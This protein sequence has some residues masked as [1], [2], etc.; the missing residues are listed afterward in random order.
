MVQVLLVLRDGEGE[1]CGR[2]LEFAGSGGASFA[3]LDQVADEIEELLLAGQLVHLPGGHDRGGV[4]LHLFN[5]SH[6]QCG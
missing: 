1:Q 4:G 3:D 5:L 2:R 6:G